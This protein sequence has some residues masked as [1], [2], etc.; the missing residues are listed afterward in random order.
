VFRI[1]RFGGT[2]ADA[3]NLPLHNAKYAMPADVAI[4]THFR[5]SDGGIFTPEGNDTARLA[6]PETFVYQATHI[7]TSAALLEARIRKLSQIL[8]ARSYLW[9]TD[10][11]DQFFRWAS[12]DSLRYNFSVEDHYYTAA[13]TFQFSLE[14]EGWLAAVDTDSMTVSGNVNVVAAGGHTMTVQHLGNMDNYRAFSLLFT[15]A[16]GNITSLVVS[17]RD[18][19]TGAIVYTTL[20]YAGTIAAA[21]PVVVDYW[22]NRLTV[23]GVIKR[24]VTRGADLI[25]EWGMLSKTQLGTITGDIFGGARFCITCVGSATS[26]VAVLSHNGMYAL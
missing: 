11:T 4:R 14:H 10:G 13:L 21:A 8:G 17:C 23:S 3:L 7:A 15:P 6:S 5:Q 9:A 2:W 19:L 20:T 16:G 12:Y 1:E 22:T 25:A 18:Y 26:Y 24:P